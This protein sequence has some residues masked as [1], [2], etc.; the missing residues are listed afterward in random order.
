[1]NVESTNFLGDDDDKEETPLSSQ[2]H[3]GSATLSQPILSSHSQKQLDDFKQDLL[4]QFEVKT[5]QLIQEQI[6]QETKQIHQEQ[7]HQE[8]KQ[9]I[10][11]DIHEILQIDHGNKIVNTTRIPLFHEIQ[12]EQGNANDNP[13]S[14]SNALV[15]SSSANN[16]Q[17]G[18][19]DSNTNRRNFLSRTVSAITRSALNIDNH[20]EQ[21]M[22][23]PQDTYSLMIVSKPYSNTWCI[24]FGI[25]TLQITLFILLLINMTGDFLSLFNPKAPEWELV[26]AQFLILLAIF[27]LQG[28]L[29]EAIQCLFFLEE[30]HVEYLLTGLGQNLTSTTTDDEVLGQD[31]AVPA[32]D[33]V[34][35]HQKNSRTW[36]WKSQYLCFIFP[37]L[38]KLIMAIVTIMTSVIVTLQSETNLDLLKEFSALMIINQ[39][40][41]MVFVLFVANGLFCG[42]EAKKKADE[43]MS[44]LRSV[45]IDLLLGAP[46]NTPAHQRARCCYRRKDLIIISFLYVIAFL[47]WVIIIRLQFNDYVF[48]EQHRDCS[49]ANKWMIKNKMCDGGDYNTEECGFDG[50]DCDA[51]NTRVDN[52]LSVGDGKCDGGAYNT[53]ECGFDGGDC[54]DFNSDYPDCDVDYPYW[55]GSGVCSGP[56]YNTTECGYDGGD[57]LQTAKK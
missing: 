53:E 23:L 32:G 10:N 16:M 5:K 47:F 38:L 2:E 18:A 11:E 36:W 27:F 22:S 17:G 34:I 52:I 12:I 48:W 30:T 50:G 39:F 7:I 19:A 28:D 43:I 40:D 37:N 44:P 42:L 21:H 4:E 35:H 55:I 33:H 14:T 1:M 24:G 20:G 46:S 51:C 54:E 15:S 41:N 45:K 29:V 13:T 56:K 31:D 6:H 9:L 8:T 57:C 49:V 25:F 3:D 26:T